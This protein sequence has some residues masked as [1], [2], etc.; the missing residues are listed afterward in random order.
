MKE[1]Q[2]RVDEIADEL[3]SAMYIEDVDSYPIVTSAQVGAI[4]EAR[5]RMLLNRVP[6][7]E[8]LKYFSE[9]GVYSSRVP[10]RIPRN[11]NLGLLSRVAF[12]IHSEGRV[13]AR[14]WLIDGEDTLADEDIAQ[15]AELINTLLPLISED[16]N[17]ERDRVSRA[18]AALR[19]LVHAGD[20]ERQSRYWELERTFRLDSYSL[21][22]TC[23]VE[24]SDL[25]QPRQVNPQP[26]RPS[27]TDRVCNAFAASIGEGFELM[28][29]ASEGALY[30]VV[31]TNRGANAVKDEIFNAARR[32][33][34]LNDLAL[35][36]VGF[37]EPISSGAGI[38][39]SLEKA[40]YVSAV[41]KTES[42]R[43]KVTS[44]PELG[45]MQIF[46]AVK[47]DL[48]GVTSICPGVGNLLSEGKLD[49]A[50]TL[51]CWL[52]REGDVEQ[53]AEELHI[54][55]TTLYYRLEKIADRVGS[56]ALK[57]RERLT[58][59]AALRLAKSCDLM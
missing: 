36:S 54:H 52:E 34:V 26:E 41:Q 27:I 6:T 31:A 38:V 50:Q 56:E 46:F 11:E 48:S 53:V 40:A 23:V 15:I 45:E 8:H 7:T 57:G 12:P 58:A 24:Y 39:R 55:R 35:M 28:A 43:E 3:G 33:G 2:R 32:A 17:S 44:W 16:E 1:L 4:D 19:D 47:W 42:D 14:A 49:L 59:H 25:V 10:V 22:T 20:V 30:A 13:M 21:V 5:V 51:L 37:G 29:Y 18:G 9:H